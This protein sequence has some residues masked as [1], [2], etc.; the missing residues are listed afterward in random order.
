M[1]TVIPHVRR[2]GDTTGLI[3]RTGLWYAE[4]RVTVKTVVRR[5]LKSM[6]TPFLAVACAARDAFYADLIAKGATVATGKKPAEMICRCGAP[7]TPYLK[8]TH[9]CC[10][11]CRATE[12]K[13]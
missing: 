11:G 5:R 6:E 12:R 2:P 13:P 1:T 8:K 7:L 4:Y 9:G 10:K 3:F